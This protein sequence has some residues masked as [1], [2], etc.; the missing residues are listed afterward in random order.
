MNKSD[1]VD[2]EMILIHETEKAVLLGKDEDDRKGTWVPKSQ[3]QIN[4]CTM[5]KK[6]KFIVSV[7]MKQSVAEEK[8][9]V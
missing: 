6:G 1:L 4:E 7:S 8:G 5:N 3:C 2:L 9:F